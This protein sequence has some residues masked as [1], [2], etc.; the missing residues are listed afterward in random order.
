MEDSLYST[1]CEEGD[2]FWM[3]QAYHTQCTLY[4][5]SATAADLTGETDS[6]PEGWGPLP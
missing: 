4:F 5:K 2:G 1:E 3:T 6:N